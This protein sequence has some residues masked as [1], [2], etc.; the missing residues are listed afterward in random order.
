[1]LK[2]SMPEGEHPG[3]GCN[4]SRVCS[5]PAQGSPGKHELMAVH[6]DC[7]F[8]QVQVIHSHSLRRHGGP[9]TGGCCSRRYGSGRGRRRPHGCGREMRTP[10]DPCALSS[11]PPGLGS[12]RECCACGRPK[13]EASSRH[14]LPPQRSLRQ[15]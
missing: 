5:P 4:E 11:N 6:Q 13:G 3:A 2:W 14:C 10:A 9:H 8:L 1:V 12:Q 15:R 7:T